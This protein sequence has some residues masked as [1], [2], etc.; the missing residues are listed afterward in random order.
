LPRQS[1]TSWLTRVV[2]FIVDNTPCA[3][4]VGIGWAVLTSSKNIACV[5]DI[6]RYDVDRI[7]VVGLSSAGLTA[8]WLAVLVG[9]VYLVWNYGYRQGATG[10]SIGK[11]VTG[12]KV[13]SENTG[14]PIG[15]GMSVLRQLAHVVDAVICYIGYLFP[16]WDAKR[17]TL[18]DKIMSTVCLPLP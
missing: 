13:V 3:V 7:C 10:S 2:A 11:S 1:Y 9:L 15:F 16:L 12:F 8:F 4:I 5:T 17:Q 14:Q 6:T 18:A